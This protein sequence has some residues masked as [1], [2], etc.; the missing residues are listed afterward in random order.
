MDTTPKTPATSPAGTPEDS[1][2]KQLTQEELNKLTPHEKT[3]YRYERDI[4]K[5]EED[6]QETEKEIEILFDMSFTADSK[7]GMTEE[8]KQA[9]IGK[10]GTLKRFQKESGSSAETYVNALLRDYKNQGN[11]AFGE[12]INAWHTYI[13]GW[14]S[15]IEHEKKERQ[16]Y[17]DEKYSVVK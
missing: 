8:R 15:D 16:A 7:E 12:A 2:F 9:F 5:L 11:T 14:K 17:L 3:L 10:M 13:D 1:L 4:A 6:I